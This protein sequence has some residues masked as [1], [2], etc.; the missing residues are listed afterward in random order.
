MKVIIGKS[1]LEYGL[2]MV[3]GAVDKKKLCDYLGSVFIRSYTGSSGVELY[4][5][6]MEL[7]ASILLEGI[8]TVDAGEMVLP[9]EKLFSVVKNCGTGNIAI[10]GEI[11]ASI[12]GAV[13]E[14][15]INGLDAA[16]FPL[17]VTDD[18][19]I[20]FGFP[21]G[22]LASCINSVKHAECRDQAK[23]NI[24]CINF[25]LTETGTLVVVA[26]DGHRMS[27]AAI[28]LPGEYILNKFRQFKFSLSHK[29]AALLGRIITSMTV[30]R[31][32]KQNRLY[33][34]S[35]STSIC[36][37]ESASEYPDVRRIIPSGHGD[38]ITVDTDA[39]I[40]AIES[41][42]IISDDAYRSIN[43][44]ISDEKITITA[45][46]TN[47]TSRSVIPCMCDCVIKIRI[48][49]TYLLQ[50]LKS[51]NSAETFI[52]YFGITAPV[53]FMPADYKQWNERLDIIMPLGGE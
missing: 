4:A 24:N 1:D 22:L 11:N 53:M 52:K 2:G 33:F 47:S 49:S 14:Y 34:Q 16:G 19:E 31:F 6:D 28:E 7:S 35:K 10:S 39:L 21:A 51:M 41:T 38:V 42:C 46:G 20:A 37:V 43:L 48:N 13:A 3:I 40:G 5:T 15:H 32:E 9:A 27:L 44:D 26:T 8:E 25:T 17:V 45:I 50:A 12:V 18:Y 23:S 29:A 30:G 36:V